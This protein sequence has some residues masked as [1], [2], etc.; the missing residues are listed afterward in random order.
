MLRDF[1]DG[2]WLVELGALADPG[3]VP[4]TV[5]AALGLVEE[6]G[7]V[8]TETLVDYLSERTLL[9]V[10]DNCEH[11]LGSCAELAGMLLGASPGLRIVASSRARIRG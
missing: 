9:L 6:R 7:R 11:L 10:L 2:V 8:L 5:A 1:V 3:L 4:Q